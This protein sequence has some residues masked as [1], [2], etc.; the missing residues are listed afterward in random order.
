MVARV[1]DSTGP[2]PAHS[3]AGKRIHE[4]W[5]AWDKAKLRADIE[6]FRFHDLSYT[7]AS[8]HVQSGTSLPELVEL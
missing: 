6:D 1:L 4:S 7:W 5:T 3:L 2:A 8:C